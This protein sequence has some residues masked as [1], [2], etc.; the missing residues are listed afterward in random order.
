VGRSLVMLLVLPAI[1]VSC[2]SDPGTAQQRRPIYLGEPD[3]VAAHQ[4]VVALV[5]DYQGTLEAFCTGTLIAPAVVLTAAHCIDDD[6]LS[7]VQIYFGDDVTAGGVFID[8]DQW[9]QHSGWDPADPDSPDDMALI[10]LAED[11]PP[12]VLPIALLPASLGL[13]EAD[14][15]VALDF[16]G[17]GET[18]DLGYDVKLHVLVPIDKVCVGPGECVSGSN[19]IPPRAFGYTQENGGPCSGDSGGPAFIWRGDY[20]FVAGV[21]SFGNDCL[22]FGVSTTVNP[23][24]DWIEDYAGI[25]G[26]ENCQAAGDDDG[27]GLADCADPDCADDPCCADPPVCDIIEPSS[28]DGGCNQS[29]HPGH[30]AAAAGPLILF[31][32][33]TLFGFVRR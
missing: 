8:V 25:S 10:R 29:G 9:Q 3:T 6:M 18:E 13:R 11:A 17:F 2:T 32:L 27:D 15:G 14:E 22:D 1:F 23:Y 16:S 5:E 24:Q 31:A 21:T 19:W 33:F 20:E 12:G 30:W 7:E 26:Q 28:N 4:A